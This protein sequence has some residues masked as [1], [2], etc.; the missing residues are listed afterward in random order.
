MAA[1]LALMTQYAE[2]RSALGAMKVQESHAV[3]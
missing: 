1:T 3:H 2:T